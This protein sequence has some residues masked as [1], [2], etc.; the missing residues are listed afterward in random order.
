VCVFVGVWIN[1]LGNNEKVG[2]K[3]FYILRVNDRTK[4][5]KCLSAGDLEMM[6]EKSHEDHRFM[7]FS[8]LC[9]NTCLCVCVLCVCNN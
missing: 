9:V 1:H 3:K 4:K 6:E 5:K 8:C 2:K 7:I